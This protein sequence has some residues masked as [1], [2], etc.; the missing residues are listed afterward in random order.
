MEGKAK[1]LTQRSQRKGGGKSE[2]ERRFTA[3]TQGA[4]RKEE[5]R[6]KPRAT[7]GRFDEAEPAATNLK[8]RSAAW[9]KCRGSLQSQTQRGG[10]AESLASWGAALR[11]GAAGSQ[12]ESP[13]RAIHKQRLWRVSP[14]SWWNSPIG[15]L[16]FPGNQFN[17]EE[18]AGR[19]RYEWRP[20]AQLGAAVPRRLI[21]AGEA[22]WARIVGTAPARNRVRTRSLSLWRATLNRTSW[23]GW[24]LAISA[25]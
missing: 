18:P 23:P 22:Y 5:A 3:E 19:R 25:L 15:R 4:Q 14:I 10:V 17:C 8:L 21:R 20:S 16:A 13:C 2:E 12:D 9:L 6:A 24:S 11:T 7:A 1:D